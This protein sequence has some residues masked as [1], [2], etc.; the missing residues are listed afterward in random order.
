MAVLDLA[1]ESHPRANLPLPRDA[2]AGPDDILV[3]TG[4]DMVATYDLFD[5]ALG[6]RAIVDENYLAFLQGSHRR[7]FLED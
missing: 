3:A 1:R 6:A 2:A 7:F 4:L 5:L